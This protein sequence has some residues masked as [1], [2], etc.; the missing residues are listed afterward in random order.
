MCSK[1]D[2]RRGRRKRRRKKKKK[3]KR[4]GDM[5]GTVE[6][7]TTAQWTAPSA[8]RSHLGRCRVSCAR[9]RG[10]RAARPPTLTYWLS[11][12]PDLHT[13]TREGRD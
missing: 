5:G 12:E 3:K 2:K 8:Q 1:A 10:A 4:G 6:F 13:V 11:P 9:H 7:S